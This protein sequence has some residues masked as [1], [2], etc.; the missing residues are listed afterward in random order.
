MV[1]SKTIDLLKYCFP[2]SLLFIMT[3]S[4]QI[5]SSKLFNKGIYT[6]KSNK[7]IEGGVIK[8]VCFDKTGT[9]TEMDIKVFGYVL[10]DQKE[11]D[12]FGSQ[13]NIFVDYQ[14]YQ[15]FIKC[16][17]CC[18]TLEIIN[19]QILGDPLEISMFKQTNC[20]LGNILH[21]FNNE[22]VTNFVHF[23]EEYQKQL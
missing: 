2:P 8:S 18:H 4:V 17:S 7:I 21:P 5:S 22:T 13:V 3:A 16:I 19:E 23:N 9:L 10:R 14:E 12:A 15:N 20:Q 6:L 1:V 11:F